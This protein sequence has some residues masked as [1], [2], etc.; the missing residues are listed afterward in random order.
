[1]DYDEVP[2][3]RRAIQ[4]RY[5]VDDGYDDRVVNGSLK[6]CWIPTGYTGST[7]AVSHWWDGFSLVIDKVP[8]GHCRQLSII[9]GVA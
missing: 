4:T 7:Q 5:R 3:G 1:M 2:S 8:M 9:L 6:V